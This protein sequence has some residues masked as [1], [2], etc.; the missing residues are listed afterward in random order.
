[1][2]IG[3]QEKKINY[4]KIKE[5]AMFYIEQKRKQVSAEVSY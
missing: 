2:N 5:P 1:M 3:I 4:P